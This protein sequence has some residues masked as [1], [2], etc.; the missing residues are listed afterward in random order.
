V[1]SPFIY[2]DHFA[3]L[4]I[5]RHHRPRFAKAL[6]RAGGTWGLSWLNF[7]EF[8]TTDEREAMLAEALMA[9]ALPNVVFLEVEGAVAATARASAQ[10]HCE[11]IPRRWR[12]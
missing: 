9:A 8:A 6:T 7:L 2:L 12:D 3:V 4:E 5:A 11:G 1:T 10:P